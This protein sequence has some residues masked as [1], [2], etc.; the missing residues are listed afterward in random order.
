MLKNKVSVAVTGFDRAENGP[1]KVWVT[2]LPVYR[3][4]GIPVI[5]VQ[6]PPVPVHRPLRVP[7]HVGV[8]EVRD[9]EHHHEGRQPRRRADA[10]A[11]DFALPLRLE[12]RF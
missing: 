1:S 7:L 4:T 10:R 8:A 9:I 11:D 3:Y 12:P 2:D 6:G 5:P